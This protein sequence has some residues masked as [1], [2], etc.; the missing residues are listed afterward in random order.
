MDNEHSARTVRI[1]TWF[2]VISNHPKCI[3][4]KSECYRWA[5]SSMV[6]HV[7]IFR[8]IL[9]LIWILKT[10]FVFLWATAR[11]LYWRRLGSNACDDYC[12]LAIVGR[13]EEYFSLVTHRWSCDD[14]R[15]TSLLD[16]CD[17]TRNASVFVAP[18]EFVSVSCASS[19]V[20]RLLDLRDSVYNWLDWN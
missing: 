17:D 20:L 16:V 18:L 19:V 6:Q 1:L 2:F 15:N 4:Y 8:S 11:R 10:R 14:T 9:V 13:H 5:W 7:W 12:A 3:F